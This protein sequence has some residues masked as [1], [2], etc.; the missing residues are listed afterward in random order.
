MWPSRSRL[1]NRIARHTARLRNSNHHESETTTQQRHHWRLHRDPVHAQRKP[2]ATLSPTQCR[3]LRALPNEPHTSFPAHP[4][5]NIC[6]TKM[7]SSSSSVCPAYPKCA[8]SRSAK[9]F[10]VRNVGTPAWRRAL[11]DESSHSTLP[12]Q[13]R[14]LAQCTAGATPM[15]RKPMQLHQGSH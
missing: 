7:S 11:H 3:P 4:A 13:H 6:R 5:S 9:S 1:T 10:A 15:F 12:K 8:S 2:V 14:I